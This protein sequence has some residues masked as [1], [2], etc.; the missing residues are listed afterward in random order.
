MPARSVSVLLVEDDLFQLEATA[1]YLLL[2][3]FNV[4]KA[5]SATQALDHLREADGAVHIGV[6]DIDL[7]GEMDGIDLLARLKK[8]W[9][10]L[11][12]VYQLKPNLSLA[13]V[14]DLTGIRSRSS[15]YVNQST[16]AI[17]PDLRML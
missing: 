16:Q 10:G 3:G 4:I 9:P 14:I 13:N 8:E 11:T 2:E 15:G 17:F 7:P 5:A 1:D 12:I 6:L